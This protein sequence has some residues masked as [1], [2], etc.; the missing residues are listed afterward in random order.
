M[1]LADDLSGDGRVEL[2]VSTMNGN[3]FAFAVDAPC[4]PM[5]AWPS[6]SRGAGNAAPP[7]LMRTRLTLAAGRNTLL[8]RFGYHGIYVQPHSRVFR[9]VLGAHVTI[10]ARTS[11][12]AARWR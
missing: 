3:V 2:V 1:V 9:D 12:C 7:L 8:T 11:A 5:A 10:Q 6:Q 4:H